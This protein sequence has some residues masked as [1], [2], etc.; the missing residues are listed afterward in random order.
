M[1]FDRSGVAGAHAA[2][3]M[4]AHAAA[5]AA[6]RPA[7]GHGGVFGV[8][9]KVATHHL[10]GLG[11]AV[12]HHRCSIGHVQALLVADDSEFTDIKSPPASSSPNATMRA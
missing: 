3:S 12:G 11:K 10:F 4:V 9:Q 6:L 8:E 5:G 2:I 7:E 1:C